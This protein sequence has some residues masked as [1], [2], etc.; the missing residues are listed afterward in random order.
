MLIVLLFLL[1]F[2][3]A[4]YLKVRVW[5]LIFAVFGFIIIFSFT[6]FQY[7]LPFAPNLQIF[8]MLIAG[9]VFLITS[10]EAVTKKNVR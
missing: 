8:I 3:I 1:V 10:I 6:S 4:L 2:I 9:L 5:V 7:E